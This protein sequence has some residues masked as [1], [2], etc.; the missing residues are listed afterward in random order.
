MNYTLIIPTLNAEPY[1]CELIRAVQAQTCPPEKFLIIDSGSEDKTASLAA[2]FPGITVREIER[3]SFDH[4][5]TRDRAIRNC[6]TPFVILMSQDA[7]PADRHCFENLLNKLRDLEIAAVTARQIPRADA[8]P[9]EQLLRQFRYPDKSMIWSKEQIG[10]MGIRSYLLSDVCAAY[11]VSDYLKAGGFEHPVST[12]EDM[13]MASALLDEG[14]RLAYCAE[15]KVIHSHSFT[16][17]QEYQRYFR[18][19]FFLAKYRD[20]FSGETQ[21]GVRMLRQITRQL[22]KQGE[23]ASCFAFWMDCLVRYA[24]SRAGKRAWK[25]ERA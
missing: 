10:E 8:S 11:R 19:G 13:L 16:L 7:I 21:E 24:G 22:L 1:I 2:S 6:R 3:C 23:I 17:R 4:G 18:I 14:Y 20:R 25:K 12:N 9:Q 15:A 5:G